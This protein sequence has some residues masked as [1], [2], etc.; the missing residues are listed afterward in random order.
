MCDHG[1]HFLQ[2]C[3][4][5]ASNSFSSESNS[6]SEDVYT[7]YL[8]NPK[9]IDHAIEPASVHGAPCSHQSPAQRTKDNMTKQ[10]RFDA[11]RRLSRA[12]LGISQR[13][14]SATP[15]SCSSKAGIP[16]ESCGINDQ[17]IDGGTAFLTEAQVVQRK[18]SSSQ[19]GAS[20]PRSKI[21]STLV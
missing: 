12:R 7:C 4:S 16:Q 15:T 14:K 18:T 2:D 6:K 20:N 21:K 19:V 1:Q 5:G 10:T 3:C 13:L 9:P 17:D 8:R 11:L